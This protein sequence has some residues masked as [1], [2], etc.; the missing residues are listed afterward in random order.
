VSVLQAGLKTEK[1]IKKAVAF[2]AR[3]FAVKA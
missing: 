3:K 2:P 1:A